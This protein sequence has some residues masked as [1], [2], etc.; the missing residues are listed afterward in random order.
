MSEMFLYIK[1][2][3]LY[4]QNNKEYYKRVLLKGE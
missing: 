1:I 2:S 3:E 4:N